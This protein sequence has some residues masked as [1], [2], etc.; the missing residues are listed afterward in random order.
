MFKCWCCFEGVFVMVTMGVSTVSVIESII[1]IRLCT[2]HPKRKP[3]SPFVRLIAFR[4]LGRLLR[5]ASPEP[6]N[7]RVRPADHRSSPLEVKEVRVQN[8]AVAV[9]SS[10]AVK[11]D[12]AIDSVL[13]ELRKVYSRY[14]VS[15][16]E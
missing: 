11:S 15:V 3:L 12:S 4:I 8:G 5:V 16:I 13:A 9:N 2:M 1:V 7:R 10:A 6:P 14:I